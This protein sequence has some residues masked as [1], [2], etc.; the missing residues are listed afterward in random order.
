METANGEFRAASQRERTTHSGHDGCRLNKAM[1]GVAD[2]A[3]IARKL[4]DDGQLELA[5]ELAEAHVGVFSSTELA[6]KWRFLLAQ[7]LE[8]KLSRDTRVQAQSI[9]RQLERALA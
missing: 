3:R 2:I 5:D 4:R 6:M 7:A 8:G 1:V 9:W